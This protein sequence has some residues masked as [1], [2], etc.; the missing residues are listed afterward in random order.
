MPVDGADTIKAHLFE[1]RAA[2]YSGAGEFFGAFGGFTQEEV[3]HQEIWQIRGRPY[4]VWRRQGALNIYSLRRQ[5]G[6]R[7]LVVVE[8][9]NQT[10]LQRAC[11]IECFVSHACGNSPITNDGN[12]IVV[13]SLQV[14]RHGH[15]ESG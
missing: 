8:D 12:H 13:T 10:A 7:H 11:I 1:N 3:F 9:H 14:A 4:K 6:D 5:A 15:A 2:A